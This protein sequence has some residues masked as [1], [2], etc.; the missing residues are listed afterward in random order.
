MTDWI[1]SHMSD[2]GYLSL[3]I[4]PEATQSTWVT[5]GIDLYNME[6]C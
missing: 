1:E 2:W 5:V 3:D 6:F 4:S